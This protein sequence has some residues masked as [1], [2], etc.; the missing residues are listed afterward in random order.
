MQQDVATVAETLSYSERKPRS[1]GMMRRLSRNYLAVAALLFLLTSYAVAAFVPFILPEE[2][3][4][5]MDL[6]DTLAAP[7]RAHPFGTDD[8][9]RDA[10]IR[11]LYGGRVSL[12]VGLA[13]A[14]LA[15]SIGI[16]VGATAGYLGGRF[17]M[18][19][20]RFADLL[21]GI[22]F[23]FILILTA[24]FTQPSVLSIVLIIGLLRWVTMARLVRG[25]FLSLKERDFVMAAQTLGSGP[26]RIMFRH[27]LPNAIAPI[28]VQITLAIAFAILS[29]SS[30]SFLGLGIQPPTPSWG[31]MLTKAQGYLIS[32]P[33]L[34]IFPGGLI[35]LTVLSFNILGDALRDVLDPRLRGAR[36]GR[37]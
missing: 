10:F 37:G 17:D 8:F 24:S 31:N 35:F 36:E 16:L 29:E 15:S 18:L 12:T 27:I 2:R 1:P 9:G 23:F 3:A 32:A 13:A 4:N 25:E 6:L 26:G 28:I 33:W 30:I 19:L 21:L 20:M 14:A 22:P 11:A 5:A 34:A 7:S